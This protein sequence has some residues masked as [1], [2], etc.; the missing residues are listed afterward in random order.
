M[1]KDFLQ[2][3]ICLQLAVEAVETS[4]C[5]NI[6]CKDCL[7]A[8]TK[9]PC[10]VCRKEGVTWTDN[11]LARRMIS[12]IPTECP[13]CG[14]KTTIGEL[15]THASKCPKWKLPCKI[16][17]CNFTGHE[18]EFIKHLCDAHKGT[19]IQTFIKSAGVE[20]NQTVEKKVF[21]DPITAKVN[22]AGKNARLGSTGKYYCQGRLEGNCCCNGYCG[23][24]N[25]CNCRAC[26]QLDIETR[27]LPPGFW[28]NNEGA[29][30]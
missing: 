17:G 18:D 12:S 15:P 25:G 20:K 19:L 1:E 3:P 16:E 28:V 13:D 11:I 22:S 14:E 9:K 6:F 29:C 26:M 30:M 2:C 24:T 7:S 10:P 5:H 4:C 27:G 23:P 21:K 8:F